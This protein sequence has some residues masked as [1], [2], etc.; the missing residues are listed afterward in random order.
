MYTSGTSGDPKG[1]VLSHE[2]IAALVRGLDLFLEQFE[3]K[4]NMMLDPLANFY[5]PIFFFS[6]FHEAYILLCIDDCGRCVF[7]LPSLS[8]YP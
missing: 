7:I 4:V 5:D 2:N 6:S 8:S 3:D 1:V